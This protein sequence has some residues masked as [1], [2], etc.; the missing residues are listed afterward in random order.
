MLACPHIYSSIYFFHLI[1]HGSLSTGV[2]SEVFL[3]LPDVG[4]YMGFNRLVG[5][6]PLPVERD[7]G[8]ATPVVGSSD[9]SGLGVYIIQLSFGAVATLE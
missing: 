5:A 2:Q 7:I 6:F 8:L 1:L 4:P 3:L 9:E